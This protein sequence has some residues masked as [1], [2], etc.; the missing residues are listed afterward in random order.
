VSWLTLFQR[1]FA[2]NQLEQIHVW[3]YN[4]FFTAL[5][6]EGKPMKPVT[7]HPVCRSGKKRDDKL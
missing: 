2:K 6:R 4:I 5:M 7:S 3:G 1:V